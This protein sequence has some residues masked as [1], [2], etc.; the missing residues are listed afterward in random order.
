MLVG[1]GS[2]SDKFIIQKETSGRWVNIRE[3][4]E[5]WACAIGAKF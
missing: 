5:D 1:F 3:S 4:A 2:L